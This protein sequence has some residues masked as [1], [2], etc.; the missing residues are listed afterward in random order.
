MYY[1]NG[2]EW[3]Q[4]QTKTKVNPRLIY[5]M[6]IIKVLVTQ[7]FIILLHLKVIKFLVIKKVTL[8]Q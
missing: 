1:Y 6:I 4:A 5:L 8:V 3:K 7:M 2:T